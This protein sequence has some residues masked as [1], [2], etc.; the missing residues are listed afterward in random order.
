MWIKLSIVFLIVILTSCSENR[1]IDTVVIEDVLVNDVLIEQNSVIVY[2][3]L[4]QNCL[5]SN[6]ISSVLLKPG[7]TTFESVEE[8]LG[9]G[10]KST[11]II[12]LSN[13]ICFPVTAN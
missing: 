11:G 5:K 9:W 2:D 4:Y 8:V 3:S 13:G 12:C 7:F 1:D 10:E 6:L